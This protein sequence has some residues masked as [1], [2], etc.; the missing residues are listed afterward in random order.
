M[1]CTW[2]YRETLFSIS[3]YL[4]SEALSPPFSSEWSISDAN[5]EKKNTWNAS[6]LPCASKRNR[7]LNASKP[8]IWGG[9]RCKTKVFS[10]KTWLP[11]DD[12]KTTKFCK[13]IILQLKKKKD[14]KQN[15]PTR[16]LS[17]MQQTQ[18]MWVWSLGQEDPLDGDMATH[19]SILACKVQWTEKPG[20]L[21][22]M[23]LQRVGH[24]WVTKHSPRLR[25][26]LVTQQGHLLYDRSKNRPVIQEMW[27]WS[28]G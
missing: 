22:F 18:E 14:T 19:S 26:S 4:L 17:A 16:N 9:Q 6:Q 2:I 24:N 12:Q 20:R 5:M 25:A 13:A 23:G 3:C 27:F 28:L 1:N 10:K 15:T 8:E 11:F 21:Q 7:A